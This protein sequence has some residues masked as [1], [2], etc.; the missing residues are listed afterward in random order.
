MKNKK[1]TRT[2]V[3]CRAKR[4]KQELIRIVK[5]NKNEILIDTNQNMERKRSIYL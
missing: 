3:G 1:L 4:E 2:C 5:S